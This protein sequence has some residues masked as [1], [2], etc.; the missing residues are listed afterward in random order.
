[1]EERNVIQQRKKRKR[2][3]FLVEWMEFGPNGLNLQNV[4]K[5]VSVAYSGERGL[6]LNHNLAENRVR[7]KM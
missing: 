2:V 6:V 7:E 1:M 4:A 5:L 3:M